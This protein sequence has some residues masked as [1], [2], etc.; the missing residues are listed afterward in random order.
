MLVECK[1]LSRPVGRDVVHLLHAKVAEL[2]AH[3]GV[4][5]STSGFQRG[6]P[7]L[8]KKH[9]VALVDCSPRHKEP[10]TIFGGEPAEIGP[11]DDASWGR[12]PIEPSSFD[13]QF[14]SGGV[15]FCAEHR[16]AAQVL[17]GHPRPLE[18]ARKCWRLP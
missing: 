18:P 2:A 10:E 4:V 14:H 11:I 15:S 12:P 7:L 16:Y 8:A 5:F 3:K 1:H 9:G 6:A 17:F 13:W